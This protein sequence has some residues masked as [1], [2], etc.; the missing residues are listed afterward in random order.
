MSFKE[1]VGKTPHLQNAWKD[2]LSALRAKD[3]EH[4]SATD[5]R[6]LQGSA[7]IDSALVKQQPNAHRWDYAIGYRHVDRK[8]DCIYWVEIHTSNDKEVKVVLDK[9]QWLREWLAGDGKLFEQFERD[10]I[11]VASGTTSFTLGAP[12]LKKFAQFGLQYKGKVL[13]IKINRDQ[14]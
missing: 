10:F 11:W 2:G 9:L 8:K 7:D 14:Q 5:T 13:R 6:Q 1:A 3:R 12:R 4:I